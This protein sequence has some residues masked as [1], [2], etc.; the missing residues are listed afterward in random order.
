[1]RSTHLATAFK[2][3]GSL[4]TLQAGKYCVDI[5]VLRYVDDLPFLLACENTL[6]V[7]ER[8][9][10][11]ALKAAGAKSAFVQRR[12]CLRWLRD[13]AFGKNPT[14]TSKAKWDCGSKNNHVISVSTSGSYAVFASSASATHLGLDVE[15]PDDK[16]NSLELAAGLFSNLETQALKAFDSATADELFYRMWRLKEAGLKFQGCGLAQGLNNTLFIPNAQRQITVSQ[17]FN[18]S[19]RASTASAFYESRVNDLDLAL[20]LPAEPGGEGLWQ[21]ARATQRAQSQSS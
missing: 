16:Y 21:V 7:L 1:M 14:P 15:I 4:C 17:N 18:R 8:Q 11:Q 9:R 2:A 10:A 19:P 5:Y 13:T 12:A 3:L 20:A 6:T